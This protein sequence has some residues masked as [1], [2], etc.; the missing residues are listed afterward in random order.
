MTESGLQGGHVCLR[1]RL[2]DSGQAERFIAEAWT[3]GALGIE[4]RAMAAGVE[5]DVYASASEVGALERLCGS[6]SGSGSEWVQQA[7][8][9]D[10]DWSEAWKAG[11]T[12]IEISSRL[13]IRPSF[14]D[15]DPS[16]GQRVVVIDPGQAF[17]TGGHASTRLVLE[18]LDRFSP[19]NAEG[20]GAGSLQGA[21]VLDVGTGSGVL[22]MAAVALG[23]ECAVGFDVDAIAVSEAARLVSQNE[24][25][26]QIQLFVG[27]IDQVA[28]QT[29]DCVL[30]NLL[31]SEMAP[32]LESIAEAV[33]PAGFLVLAGI[34]DSDEG[35]IS[36][37][38]QT[39]GFEGVGIRSERDDSGV[40]WVAPL[41]QR[42]S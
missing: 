25:V 27:G 1:V 20:P 12:V 29:F 32:I 40:V 10:T 39:L 36:G 9:D 42:G 38:L 18:W 14:V 26:D 31:K 15:F 41:Y 7:A 21:R 34:L 8:V 16:P 30:A 6:F 23:A 13:A 22:S 19:E 3:L 24:Q 28:G 33:A 37:R 4:E 17:G 5:L 11:L 2:P 35:E